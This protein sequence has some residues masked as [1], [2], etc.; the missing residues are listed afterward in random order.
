P[1]SIAWPSATPAPPTRRACE[2]A[3]RFGLLIDDH[4]SISERDGMSLRLDAR[5]GAAALFTGPSGAGKSTLLRHAER[6]L[7]DRNVR[8]LRLGDVRLRERPGVDLLRGQVDRAL[9][10]LA[11][12]GLGQ[13]DCFLRRPSE[14]SDGQRWRLRLALAIDAL[15]DHPGGALLVDECCATLD[16]GSTLAACATLR[17]AAREHALRVLCASADPAL[18]DALRPDEIVR[19][20]APGRWTH[21]TVSRAADSPPP[22]VIER[23]TMRDYAA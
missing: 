10:A 8:R 18:I 19:A 13:A 20:I 1:I 4:L 14:L 23:G 11:R 15:R 22:V 7:V 6:A 5:P 21:E 3:S 16:P 12:V 2:A 9:R 17:R